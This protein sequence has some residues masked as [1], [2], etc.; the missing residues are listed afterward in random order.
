MKHYNLK[1]MIMKKSIILL[2]MAH[3]QQKPNLL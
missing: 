2:A 1:R 3:L